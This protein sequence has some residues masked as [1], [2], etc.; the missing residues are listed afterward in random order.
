MPMPAGVGSLHL[1]N[2]INSQYPDADKELVTKILTTH[3]QR[4]L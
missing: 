3:M 2:I 4:L 1:N